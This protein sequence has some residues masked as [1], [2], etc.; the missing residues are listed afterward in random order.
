MSGVEAHRQTITGESVRGIPSGTLLKGNLN[1]PVTVGR[2]SS[3]FR[4]RGQRSR[5][6]DRC[7]LG[8]L[9]GD[10]VQTREAS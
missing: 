4:S 8:G 6:R 2:T 3:A 5:G 10:D 7:S 9:S 1:V